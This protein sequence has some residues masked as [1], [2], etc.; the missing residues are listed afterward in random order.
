MK[1]RMCGVALCAIGL[2]VLASSSPAQAV[3]PL[4]FGIAGGVSI[5]SGNTSDFFKVGYDVA[6]L[7]DFS[8]PAIPVGL[9]ADV[10]YHQMDGKSGTGGNLKLFGGD[11]NLLYMIPIASAA[12]AGIVRPYLTGGIGVYNAKFDAD[13]SD[14]NSSSTRFAINGGA[15][16]RFDLAGFGTFIEGRFLNIFTRDNSTQAIPINVGIMFGGY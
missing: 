14:L 11:L 15:G 2:A 7:L 13:N 10:A 4:K 12:T 5:P 3:S 9:R 16:I 8:V 1:R 6:G